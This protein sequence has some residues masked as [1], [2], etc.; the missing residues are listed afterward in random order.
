MTYY[1]RECNLEN[2]NFV[3]GELELLKDQ[4]RWEYMFDGPCPQTEQIS[5]EEQQEKLDKYLEKNKAIQLMMN[6]T[7]KRARQIVRKNYER[8]SRPK[9]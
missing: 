4:D 1:K 7:L 6:E 3:E 5:L 2:G 8:K 9:R